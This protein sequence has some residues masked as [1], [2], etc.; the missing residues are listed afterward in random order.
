MPV[1]KWAGKN[2]QGKSQKGEIDAADKG[3]ATSL[4]RRQGITATSVK[5]KPKDLEL[6][7]PG[8]QPGVS[9]KDLVTFTR[10]FATMIDA[11]LPLVQCLEILGGQTENKFFGKTIKKVQAD[12]EGG[13]TFAEALKKHP[14]SFPDLYCNMVAAGEAGATA[15]I[16]PGGS[17]RDDE[18]IAAANERGM[19]MAFTGGRHFRH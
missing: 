8:M 18:V 17:K 9:E 6:K 13:A 11:G 1:F 19:A 7:I 16:Q 12:V 2:R 5:P 15:A 3:A 14:R 4:L 10:Q